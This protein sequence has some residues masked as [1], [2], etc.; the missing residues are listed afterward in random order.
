MVRSRKIGLSKKLKKT[1]SVSNQIA[2]LSP[3]S[4]C[5]TPVPQTTPSE[6][7]ESTL[8][9]SP[10]NP[11]V[12]ELTHEAEILSTDAPDTVSTD[13]PDT[14]SSDYSSDSEY[15]PN[16]DSMSINNDSRK[17]KKSNPNI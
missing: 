14:V 9:N 4:R 6:E 15:D 5:S 12:M 10:K 11:I 3:A 7:I 16:D 1:D 17:K 8:V 2:T 13:A